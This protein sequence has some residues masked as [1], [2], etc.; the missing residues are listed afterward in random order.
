MVASGF[1]HG[2][3]TGVPHSE[4]FY[5]CQL[6]TRRGTWAAAPC[7]AVCSDRLGS[8]R[9]QWRPPRSFPPRPTAA[10]PTGII[11][12]RAGL[13]TPAA[14]SNPSGPAWELLSLVLEFL[15]CSWSS[16]SFQARSDC[17]RTRGQP[18]GSQVKTEQLW[19]GAMPRA[20][21][22]KCR[23]QATCCWYLFRAPQGTPNPYEQSTCATPRPGPSIPVIRPWTVP[24]VGQANQLAKN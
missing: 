13:G 16:R 24:G 3:L 15:E 12:S 6:V 21:P 8:G 2:S 20:Q 17:A 10:E 22:L 1:L 9:C 19:C 7:L 14:G 5:K 18:S 11:G 4:N 23:L